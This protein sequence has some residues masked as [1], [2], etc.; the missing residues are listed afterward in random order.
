MSGHAKFSPSACSRW[1][2]C[3]GSIN[4]TKDIKQEFSH[5][6]AVGTAAHALLETC[7]LKNEVPESWIGEEFNGHKVDMQMAEAIEFAVETIKNIKPKKCITQVEQKIEI[8]PHKCYG[9]ADCVLYDPLNE[10]LFII[11]YK[12]GRGVTVEAEENE[13]MMC[14]G[15]GFIEK[16]PV[17]AI[18]LMIIQ[19]NSRDSNKLVSTWTITPEVL[20]DFKIKVLEAIRKAESENSDYYLNP[21]DWCRWCPAKDSSCTAIKKAVKKTTNLPITIPKSPRDLST[22]ELKLVLD[23][24]KLIIDWLEAVEKRCIE[25]INTGTGIPGYRIENKLSNTTWAVDQE[26]L[27]E[28]YGDAIF[29]K[30][31]LSPTQANKTLNIP[32]DFT[33]R[34]VTGQKLTKEK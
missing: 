24:K 1:L 31:I 14:Y 33:T 23:N 4:L 5:H 27:E 16:M 3:P 25:A 19:P 20:L 28:L 8:I 13:Q 34:T 29:E 21:G 22:K 9:T 26:K 6:A 15:L 2:N 7:L 17:A 12:N 10:H 11:D 30:K 32:E 18:T